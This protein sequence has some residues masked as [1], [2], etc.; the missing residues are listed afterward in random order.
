MIKWSNI[1]DRHVEGNTPFGR[2][3]IRF[4]R[5]NNKVTAMYTMFG[6]TKKYMP[7]EYAVDTVDEAKMILTELTKETKIVREWGSS[8][9]SK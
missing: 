8:L 2:V 7:E 9:R 3:Y 1:Q 5:V 4:D 6:T